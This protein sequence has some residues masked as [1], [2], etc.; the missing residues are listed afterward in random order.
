MRWTVGALAGAAALALVAGCNTA[1]PEPEPTPSAGGSA[2]GGPARGEQAPPR[3]VNV[4]EALEVAQREFGALQKRDWAA[5]WALWTPEARKEVP[6]DVFVAVNRACPAAL[7][8]VAFQL[9]QVQ[10]V[11]DTAVELTWRRGSA[12]GHSALRTAGGKWGFDPG[13]GL[14][15]DYAAGTEAGIAKRKTAKT[16]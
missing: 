11:S 13:A 1:P 3:N 6:R 14:T 2:P 16:C 8:G 7:G 5:A 9:Q 10:P 4:A 12:V 15:V